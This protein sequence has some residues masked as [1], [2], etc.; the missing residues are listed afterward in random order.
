V[1][2]FRLW[3]AFLPLTV[4]P[5]YLHSPPESEHASQANAKLE[6]PLLLAFHNLSPHGNEQDLTSPAAH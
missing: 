4:H 1:W 2:M 6:L 5:S 3:F